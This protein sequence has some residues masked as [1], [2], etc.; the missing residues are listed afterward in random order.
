[1]YTFTYVYTFE[2]QAMY[3]Y[4][5]TYVQTT[6]RFSGLTILWRVSM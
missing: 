5:C 2:T 4:L 3:V 6:Y 1:M